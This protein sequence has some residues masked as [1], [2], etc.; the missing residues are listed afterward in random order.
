MKLFEI[1][2]T[3]YLYHKDLKTI[4]KSGLF[5]KGF[6]L[7]FYPDI[8]NFPRGALLH[9]VLYGAKEGRK[10]NLFFDPLWYTNTYKYSSDRIPLV[11]YIDEGE[12]KGFK[13][14]PTFDPKWYTQEYKLKR[15][16]ALKHFLKIGLPKRYLPNKYYLQKSLNNNDKNILKVAVIIHAY[17]LEMIPAILSRVTNT[18][19]NFNL[20]F[21]VSPER[22]ESLRN[23]LSDMCIFKYKLIAQPDKGYD[24]APFVQLLPKLKIEGYN[25]ICK[26]HTKK[27]DDEI[28]KLWFKLLIDSI[29]GSEDTVKRIIAKFESE[30]DLGLV[31][32]I[33]A[34]KSAQ[35]LMYG[36]TPFVEKILST[37]SINYDLKNDWG[38]FAG[39]MFWANLDIFKP[40]MNNK[41]LNDLILEES[42]SETTGA[43]ASLFH[44]IE[45]FFGLLPLLTNFNT[46]LTYPINLE[47]T[48]YTINTISMQDY[49]ISP[50]AITTTLKKELYMQKMLELTYQVNK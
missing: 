23:L 47:K 20:I 38:F 35:K 37:T 36:N 42:H 46:A 33:D 32:G 10:P 1:I 17:H 2:K 12:K 16:S 44:A 25:I 7:K 40:L 4:Y 24:I 31:G 8:L 45:R 3:K 41:K 30:R 22:E 50:Q 34:Y 39:T 27:S 18:T 13:P 11:H 9:Y 49:H 26:L 19:L 15:Q 21:T 43:S 48:K 5:D 14:C 28:G 29:F 6:Y